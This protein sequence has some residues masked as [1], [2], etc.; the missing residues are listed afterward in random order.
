MILEVKM[1]KNLGFNKRTFFSVCNLSLIGMFLFSCGTAS[2][3]K[4]HLE[5]GTSSTD[6]VRLSPDQEKALR[7]WKETAGGKVAEA[8]SFKE[9]IDGLKGDFQKDENVFKSNNYVLIPHKNKL[10]LFVEKPGGGYEVKGETRIIKFLDMLGKTDTYKGIPLSDIKKKSSTITKLT[11][12]ARKAQSSAKETA[13]AAANAV[14][15]AT[16]AQN[17]KTQVKSEATPAPVAAP[18][19][20]ATPAAEAVSEAAS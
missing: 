1:Y 10:I 17:A 11:N 14:A 18:A 20:P 4:G 9:M 19:V 13:Q 8:E 7:E 2:S 15:G 3:G 16:D 6:A 5:N 12:L